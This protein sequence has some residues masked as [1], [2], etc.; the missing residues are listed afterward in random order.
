VL[1]QVLQHGLHAPIPVFVPQSQELDSCPS[2]DAVCLVSKRPS[3]VLPRFLRPFLKR[4]FRKESVRKVTVSAFV[5][6][7]GMKTMSFGAVVG[8]V[9]N[10]RGAAICGIVNR[11]E[12]SWRCGH[13]H[14][15]SI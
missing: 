9:W 10:T 7:I 3:H 1:G 6:S 14:P 15:R 4:C 11:V 12:A 5:R 2:K 13:R 8:T